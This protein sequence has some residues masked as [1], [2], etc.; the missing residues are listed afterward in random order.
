[1]TRAW[2]V[3]AVLLLA[4]AGRLAGTADPLDRIVARVN[5]QAVLLSDV[6]VAQGL[7]LS[8][9]PDQGDLASATRAVVDQQL[10][11]A[12]AMRGQA[13]EPAAALVDQEVA[14]II[15]RAGGEGAVQALMAASGVSADH[16]RRLARESLWIE[17]YLR[18]RF[19]GGLGVPSA[20]AWLAELRRRASITCGVPGC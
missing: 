14:A 10:V 9:V 2:G 12:E 3:V 5:G 7:K 8:G 13:D 1:M 16:V 17:A 6:R 4:A 20:Q 19:G 18:Q 15:S 11:L